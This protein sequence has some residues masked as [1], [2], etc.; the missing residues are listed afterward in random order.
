MNMQW[1]CIGDFNAYLKPTVKVGGPLVTSCMVRDF[2][3]CCVQTR[4]SNMSATGLHYT[5]SNGS[6]WSKL[7]R[8]L[9]NQE[10]AGATFNSSTEFLAPACIKII[11]YVL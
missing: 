4:L 3:G 2:E 9:V 8:A 10:W 7:D 11:P 6:I 5:W 1:L